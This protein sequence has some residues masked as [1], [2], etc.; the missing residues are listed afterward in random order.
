MQKIN[1]YL[2]IS[3]LQ[4]SDYVDPVYFDMIRNDGCEIE[5]KVNIENVQ[6]L[7]N[8]FRRVNDLGVK[9]SEHRSEIQHLFRESD[10]SV[11]YMVF[12]RG[13]N[14]IWFKVKSD[15]GRIIK[16]EVTVPLVLRQGQK[17]KP[18]ESGYEDVYSRIAASDYYYTF[19]KE[20]L[21]YYFL[22]EK[23]YYSLSISLAYN[24][25]GFRHAQMEFEYEGYMKGDKNPDVKEILISFE[26]LLNSKFGIF[27]DRFNNV[28]K[29]DEISKINNW[30]L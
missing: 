10:S 29:Y 26:H 16:S 18:G 23:K 5:T 21:N 25:I 6:D 27:K 19:N 9:K 12:V 2:E 11:M 30:N 22:F 8:V 7:V 28:T 15:I 3:K 17:T 4:V 1:K 13:L 24:K 14:V 20:C